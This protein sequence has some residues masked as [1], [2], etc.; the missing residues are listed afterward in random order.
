VRIFGD[1]AVDGVKT[2]LQPVKTNEVKPASGDNLVLND[3]VVQEGGII[4]CG[5]F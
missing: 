1:Q 3:L 2:F 5:E 4:D